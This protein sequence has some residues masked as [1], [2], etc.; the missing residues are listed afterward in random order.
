[1]QTPT[2]PEIMEI[3]TVIFRDILDEPTLVVREDLTAAEVESWDSLNHVDLIVAVERKFGVKFTTREV[4]SL[5]NVGD[6]AAL[7]QTKLGARG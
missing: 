1:M 5:R 6:L 7:T 4:N 2:I 3:L